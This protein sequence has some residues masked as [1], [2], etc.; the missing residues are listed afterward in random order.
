MGT[1]R[2]LEVFGGVWG[3]SDMTGFSGVLVAV[4]GTVFLPFFV[5][6]LVPL[7]NSDRKCELWA[8]PTILGFTALLSLTSG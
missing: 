6:L 4:C 8:V 2:G 1:V 7:E 3:V 5:F